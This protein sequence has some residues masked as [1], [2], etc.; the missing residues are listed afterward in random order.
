MSG[1]D[2]TK[3]LASKVLLSTNK[4]PWTKKHCSTLHS[5]PY[6]ALRSSLVI[7]ILIIQSPLARTAYSKIMVLCTP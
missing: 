3:F 7:V 5:A 1:A 6:S 4:Q 2:I